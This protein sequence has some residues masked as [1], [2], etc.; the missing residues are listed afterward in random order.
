MYTKAFPIS[1]SITDRGL[2]ERRPVNEDSLLE[3]PSLGVFAVADGV[4]G[5]EGGEIAS[6]MAIEILAEAVSNAKDDV[7]AAELISN[8]IVRANFAIFRLASDLTQLEGMATTIAVLLIDGDKAVIA[9]V[10]DSRVYRYDI[11]GFLH[12]ETEDH[13]IVNREKRAGLISPEAAKDH[14]GRGILERALGAY[15]TVEIDLRRIPVR[16]GDRFLLCT[17]G[18]TD[19]VTDDEIRD[20][21]ANASQPYEACNALKDLCYARGANDNLTAIS[22]HMAGNDNRAAAREDERI[23]FELETQGSQDSDDNGVGS[24]GPSVA[25]ADDSPRR[26]SD[27]TIFASYERSGSRFSSP[28]FLSALRTMS[29]LVSGALI[30]LATYH[31]VFRG[32]WHATSI[33]ELPQMS[34]ENI[35]LTSFEKNRRNV[36]ADP[37]GFLREFPPPADAEDH[38][39]I[40]R[41]KLLTGD[42]GS[43]KEEFLKAKSGLAEIDAANRQ[44][45]EKEIKIGISIAETSAAQE[46]LKKELGLGKP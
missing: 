13:S 16:P 36:D 3:I 23:L 1:A 20:I 28:F 5:R 29:L 19:H 34:S 6:Q 40:G 24:K 22:V 18:I 14:P 26:P 7:D 11:D 31:L 8:A 42:F 27:A 38:Y 21:L 39:L 46:R 33:P 4:G 41:A 35:P 30:G 45:L 44:T 15:E 43:A 25:R 2:N 12:R 37:A 17:D 32:D 9:H 10:G